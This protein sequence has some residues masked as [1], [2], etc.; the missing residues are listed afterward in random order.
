MKKY[1]PVVLALVVGAYSLPSQADV[2]G[3]LPDTPESAAQIPVAEAVQ[4][5]MSG[6]PK[7]VVQFQTA[8]ADIGDSYAQNLRDFGNYLK[9]NPGSTASIVAYADHTGSGP[10]N[11]ALAQKRADAVKT[12]LVD[13]CGIAAERIT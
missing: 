8:H 7:L 12:H 5:E 3:A 11:G 13:R 2:G 10:A 1:I 6:P 4:G 9:N